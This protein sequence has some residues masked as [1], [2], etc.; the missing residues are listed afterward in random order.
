MIISGTQKKLNNSIYANLLKILRG[1]NRFLL[2]LNHYQS[3]FLKINKFTINKITL[4]S[5]R[6]SD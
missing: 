2:T 1:Y 3:I 4:N 6:I 5:K